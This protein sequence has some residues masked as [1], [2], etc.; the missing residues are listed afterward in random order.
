M[1]SI[2][3]KKSPNRR[4]LW[5]LSDIGISWVAVMTGLNFYHQNLH[6]PAYHIFF[7]SQGIFLF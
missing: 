2:A 3:F 4:F 6:T 1:T 5:A 7:Q